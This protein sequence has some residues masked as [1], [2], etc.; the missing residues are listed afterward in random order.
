MRWEPETVNTL[1]RLLYTTQS[2]AIIADV[3]KI[4][5]AW[6]DDDERPTPSGVRGQLQKLKR[7]LGNPS[8]FS[9]TN[10]KAGKA[11]DGG[12]E[13]ED[14][15]TPRTPGTPKKRGR[16]PGK[17]SDQ[18]NATSTPD[19]SQ[20]TPT[21]KVKP[22]KAKAAAGPT[23]PGPRLGEDPKVGTQMAQHQAAERPHCGGMVC[24]EL[25]CI[26]CNGY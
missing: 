1:W 15:G 23:S 12:D 22:S 16:K 4:A 21:K 25:D 19:G 18:N 24:N 8:N 2:V 11:Q 20:A 17:V 3:E 5:E 9:I 7:T 13:N 14:P 6:P 26:S 10:P